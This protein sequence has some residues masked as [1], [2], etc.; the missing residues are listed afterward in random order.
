MVVLALEASIGA[1]IMVFRRIDQTAA[2]L[3]SPYAAWVAFATYLNVGI[4]WLN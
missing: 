4:W 2:R 3:L 1:T